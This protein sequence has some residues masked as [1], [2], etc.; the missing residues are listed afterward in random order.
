MSILHLKDE[1]VVTYK[2]GHFVF[3]NQMEYIISI[4][5]FKY[6]CF[7]A[8]LGQIIVPLLIRIYINDIVNSG[9]ILYFVYSLLLTQRYMFKIIIMRV[10]LK[11]L[12]MNWYTLYLKVAQ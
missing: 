4:I 2:M 8:S 3:W 12:T 11:S 1:S 6:V 9:N 10:R 5:K 7:T